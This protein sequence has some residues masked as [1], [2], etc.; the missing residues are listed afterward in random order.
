MAFDKSTMV[1]EMIKFMDKDDGSFVDF[2]ASPAD[3]ASK[4][5]AAYD[6]AGGAVI[7]ES[8]DAVASKN[9]AGFESAIAA[10]PSPSGTAAA[11]ATQFGLAQVGYWAGAV[12]AI[13]TLPLGTNCPNVGGNTIFASEISSA[14]IAALGVSLTAALT[15]EFGTLGSGS[16]VQAIADALESSV[17]S[18][19]TVLITGLDTTPPAAG[20]LPVTNTC[21]VM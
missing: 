19:I 5:S 18:E 21:V 16:K 20:P 14:V 4:M 1:T 17:Q 3:F 8:M 11:A 12:F 7:D 10:I 13:G 2:P 15:T 9:P 6:L